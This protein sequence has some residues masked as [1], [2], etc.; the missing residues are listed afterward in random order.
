MGI[1]FLNNVQLLLGTS[2]IITIS[3]I[4]TYHWIKTKIEIKRTYN[5]LKVINASTE[6]QFQ[7]TFNESSI[8]HLGKK[9]KRETSWDL[10]KGYE[11]NNSTTFLYLKNGVLFDII[12]K[13]IIGE[14]FYH[15]FQT[16]L[17]EKL[18]S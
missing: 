4:L 13:E 5:Q 12:S 3:S 18:K 15:E 6:E 16:I 7:F 11:I 8:N 2:V 17:K 1:Y 14:I 9:T 10:I